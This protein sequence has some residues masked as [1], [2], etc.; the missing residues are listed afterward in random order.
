MVIAPKPLLH[1]GRLPVARHLPKKGSNV[2]EK[3]GIR[4]IAGNMVGNKINAE[5]K[6]YAVAIA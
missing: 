4:L 5:K 6:N 1:F 2:K 3:Q